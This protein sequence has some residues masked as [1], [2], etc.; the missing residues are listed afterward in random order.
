MITF[1]GGGA[2]GGPP[3]VEATARITSISGTGAI[4]GTTVVD[5]GSGYFTQ[6]TAVLPSTTGT[7]ANVSGN[8]DF[9]Y[10]FPKDDNGDFTTIL[11]NVLTRFSGNIGTIAAF[12]EINPGNNYNFDPFVL[13][14]TDGIAKFDRKDFII[15]L[16]DMKVEGGVVKQFNIGE[17]INQTVTE[18]GQTLEVDT[19]AGVNSSGNAFTPT[20]ADFDGLGVVQVI[21]STTNTHG[22][23]FGKNT[24][25]LEVKDLKIKT[26]DSTSNTF[27]VATTNVEPFVASATN[28]LQVQQPNTITTSITAKIT[29]TGT[30]SES[31]VAKGQVYKFDIDEDNRT[32][33]VGVRRLSFSVGFSP[34]GLIE[35]ATTEAGGTIT[36]LIY[37]DANTQPIGDNAQINADAQAANG[38]VTGLEIT[39]SGFGYQHGANLTLIS[40]NT[41]QN[42]VVSGEANVHFTGL[43]PGYWASKESFLNTKYLHDN[44][45]YQE[46]SYVIESGLS[47]N[48]YRDILLKATH[49]AGTKLFGRVFKESL[50]NNAVTI[51]NSTVLTGNVAANNTIV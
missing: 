16:K 3:K 38:I 27:T 32:G 47:L 20:T 9:G 43:G 35:G 46:Y 36:G 31:Q 18:A 4:L 34:S 29:G 17:F 2:G 44:D 19:F 37:P 23:V 5:A 22:L 1:T 45:F 24:T 15:N 41:D 40:S 12:S 30:T 49:L 14:R 26:F 28:L 11:D 13:T 50:V 10:G 48:K 42:I 6:A 51:A 33:E 21:N 39:D 8:F 25:H 7:V